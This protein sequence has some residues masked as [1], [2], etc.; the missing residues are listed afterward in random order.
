MAVRSDRGVATH[1][2][3]TND[4]R[5]AF[6]DLLRWYAAC[7]APD[8]DPREVIELLLASGALDE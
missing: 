4:V 7:I 3:R 8:E 1:E 2:A 5:G 6:G